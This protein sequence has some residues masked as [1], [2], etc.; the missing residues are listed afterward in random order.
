MGVEPLDPVK[1]ENMKKRLFFVLCIAV[2]AMLFAI[3][4][5]A[6]SVVPQKPTLDVDFGAVTT[7]PEFTPPSELYKTTTERVLLVDGEGNYVT[8]PTY[9][10]TKDSTTFDFDFSKCIFIFT[11]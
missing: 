3:A 10:V 7:I 8:Y 1:E 11:K 9:Y 6:A 2:C 5:S 4:V